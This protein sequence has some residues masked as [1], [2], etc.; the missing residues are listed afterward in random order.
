M[1]LDKGKEFVPER[2][3]YLDGWRGLAIALVLQAHFFNV[4]VFDSG[5]LGV[6]I[7]FVLSG[8]LMSK[9]LFVKRTPL[10]LFYERRV[11]RILPVFLLF[12]IT[13]FLVAPVFGLSSN[14]VEFASTLIFLRTYVPAEPDIW[15]STLPIGHLWSLN[16]EEHSY[17]F[18]S[19][20]TLI[21]FIKKREVFVLISIGVLAIFT[22]IYYAK[23]LILAP[24]GYEL[25]T[26]CAISFIM[27][28][29]GYCLVKDK[30]TK[31]VWPFIPVITLVFAI[32]CYTNA[33]PWWTKILISPFLLSF[34][35]NHLSESWT[36]MLDALSFKPLILLGNWSY[37]I[38]LWQQPFYSYKSYFYPGVA[39]VLS[40]IVSIFSFYIFENPT[41]QWLNER[42]YSLILK[43]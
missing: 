17:I 2:I 34:T 23:H 1:K 35:A 15:N 10:P 29:A 42:K 13:V 33:S 6:D 31:F 20:L 5:R 36:G 40:I 26:E 22:Q 27:I 8:L 37:S 3:D 7:F 32:L 9:I 28:S 25:R 41:R 39:F 18:M 4:I 14:I 19:L 11:S 43:T 24:S 30:V 16:V 38:Y 12:V 21:A